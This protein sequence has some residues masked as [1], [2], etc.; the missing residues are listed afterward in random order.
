MLGKKIGLF[1]LI[2]YSISILYA[3][4]FFVYAGLDTFTTLDEFDDWTIERKVESQTNQ[5]FCRASMPRYGSWFGSRIRLDSQDK[6]LYPQYLEK[7]YEISPELMGKLRNALHKCRSSII[8]S[9]GE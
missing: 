8:Y 7:N 9:S 2:F 5:L 1:R 4:N 3:S 6:L